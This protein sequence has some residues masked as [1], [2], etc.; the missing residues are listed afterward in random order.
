M[1]AWRAIALADDYN[2]SSPEW[3]DKLLLQD[4]HRV[5]GL[6]SSNPKDLA[7]ALN[8]PPRPGPTDAQRL[9]R[10]LARI[11]IFLEVAHLKHMQQ[12]EEEFRKTRAS[13]TKIFEEVADKHGVALTTVRDIWYDKRFR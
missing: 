8:M 4:V 13:D 5:A 1:C 3:A 11:D 6:K 12:T 2:L 10:D 9:A 7:A